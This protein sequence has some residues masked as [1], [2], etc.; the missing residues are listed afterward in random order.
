[1]K[2]KNSGRRKA[3]RLIV[4]VL[5]L[6]LLIAAMATSAAAEKKRP[7]YSVETDHKAVALGINSAWGNEDIDAILEVLAAHNV[8][9]SF[10]VLGGWADKYPESVAKIFAAGHEVGSHSNTHTDMTR[11]S[12]D[13]A[14]REIRESVRKIEAITGRRPTLFRPPS[15][16]YNSQ[17]IALIEAEGLYPI[18]WD[19]D[20]LDYRDLTADQMW[21]R[22]SKNLKSGSILL[23]HSGTKN[24]AGALP[25]IIQAVRDRGYEFVPVSELIHP[26]PYT[27]DFAGRQRPA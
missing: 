1:M 21:A 16:D 27:V 17:T 19:C 18:Q 4:S 11:L 9:A 6:F 24:T 23:F 5:A 22:I 14:R 13:Q 26:K 20:S 7:I 25:Q 10:F 3:G 15:G 12:D 8:R 2:I